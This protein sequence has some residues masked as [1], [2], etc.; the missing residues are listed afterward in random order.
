[1]DLAYHSAARLALMIREGEVSAEALLEH[2]LARMTVCNPPLNAVVVTDV[3]AA[4]QRARE[5]DAALARGERW[6]PLHGVPMTV[7]ETY[8][9]VGMPTT[10]GAP[11]LREHRSTHNAVAVQRLLDAGAVIYG[12]TNVPLFAGDLQTYNAIYGTTVNP[13]N[14]ECTPGGSS[15][16]SAA[17]LAAGLT[18]LELGSDIGGSIRTPASFCGVCG[19]KPSYGI[20]SMRGHIP[21][22]PGSL[23]VADI[24]VAGPLARTV[25]DLDLAIGLLLGPDPEQATG[26]RVELPPARH[27]YGREFRVAAW[28]DDPG[29]PVDAEVVALLEG[30]VER[31]RGEGIAIDTAARPAGIGI[32]R[33]HDTYYQLLTATMGAGLPEQVFS[34]MLAQA[35]SAAPDDTGYPAR[36]ARG[37]T[38]RH[39]QWLRANETRLHM[40]EAWQTFFGAFDVMLAPAIHVPP[41]AHDHGQPMAERRLPVNGVDRPYMDVLTWAGL[42]GVVHL[43]ATVVPVGRTR[44]GL[45]VGVQ[46]IGPYLED[47]TPLAFARFVEAVTGGFEAPP[48]Y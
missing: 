13:W 4:R 40:R 36:F 15:G 27:D 41:F 37:A 21:G 17:A 22:P 9:I 18:P 8:E 38:Q 39:A 34:G 11:S 6:G 30:L 3:D 32:A 10:A 46:I 45:P 26:W 7:K 20:V 47:A 12:K 43:P 24:S 33:S 25:D 2:L 35:D 19:H 1:M 5:A 44:A 48:G 28:L 31:L 42:A 14:P 29:C 16:G 23:S